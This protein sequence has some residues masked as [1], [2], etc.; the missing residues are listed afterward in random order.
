M[1][2]IKQRY[3]RFS[4]SADET[5]A[6]FKGYIVYSLKSGTAFDIATPGDTKA[7]LIA[8]GEHLDADGDYK[9]PVSNLIA[10][11]SPVGPYTFVVVALDNTGNGEATTIENVVIDVTPPAAVTNLRVD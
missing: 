6:D 1:S 11:L 8:K 2:L 5:A 4:P 7:V 9:I 3:V 10:G